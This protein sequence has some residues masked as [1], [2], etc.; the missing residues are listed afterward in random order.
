MAPAR[1]FNAMVDVHAHIL[2]GL[3]DGPSDL[4]ASLAMCR[5]AVAD[6]ITQMA[7]T[8]HFCPPFYRHAPREISR[9]V[10]AL[11]QALAREGIPLRLYPGAD[12]SQRA[13][14]LGLAR[15]GRLPTL[16]GQG[17]Y[18]LL[19]PVQGGLRA[20]AGLAS[21]LRPLGLRPII[22]HPE[23]L[24]EAGRGGWS[25]LEGLVERG[26]LVQ[27]TAMS[28]TG[29][30]GAPAQE[31][32]ED[33]LA[34]GLVHLVASDAHSTGRRPPLLSPARERL[35]ELVGEAGAERLLRTWPLAVLEG[36]DHL[37]SN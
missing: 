10:A 19:E 26:C 32:A 31:R 6:G 34:R 21:E 9:A 4:S 23:R 35:I 33:L 8:P 29:G 37:A 27:I 12:V 5:L 14:V 24:A 1:E 3:D 7:A 2:P 11:A 20:L 18:F 28:L 36:K 17:R 30:F 13:D 16:A 22:T 25:W 15:Q